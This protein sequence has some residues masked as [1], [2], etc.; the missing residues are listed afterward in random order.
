MV[1]GSALV[2]VVV[3]GRVGGGASTAGDGRAGAAV[4]CKIVASIPRVVVCEV[5]HSF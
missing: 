3:S 1:G 2:E 5:R 4:G